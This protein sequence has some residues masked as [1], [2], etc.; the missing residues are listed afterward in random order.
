VLLFFQREIF[1]SLHGQ[2]FALARMAAEEERIARAA[3]AEELIARAAAAERASLLCEQ[4]EQSAV[5]AAALAEEELLRVLR[6]TELERSSCRDLQEQV[7]MLEKQAAELASRSSESRVEIGNK[8]DSD[9]V[10]LETRAV[11]EDAET[12]ALRK[13]N[14]ALDEKLLAF[15]SSHGAYAERLAA[16]GRAVELEMQLFLAQIAEA[17]ARLRVVNQAAPSKREASS[18]LRQTIAAMKKQLGM[19]REKLGELEEMLLSSGA[20]VA[21]MREQVLEYDG[22]SATLEAEAKRLEEEASAARAKADNTRQRAHQAR[23]DASKA[24]ARRDAIV[25]DIRL[26]QMQRLAGATRAVKDGRMSP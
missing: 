20:M 6:K 1:F 25:A 11:E 19:Y 2:A 10:K 18:L 7:H 13:E 22:R 8:F 14:E 24:G 5:A 21:S 15:A 23:V 3:E 26:L 12:D 9:I 16:E 17:E 4:R